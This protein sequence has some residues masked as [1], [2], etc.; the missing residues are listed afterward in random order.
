MS[1]SRRSALWL[2][3]TDVLEKVGGW[4]SSLAQWVKELLDSGTLL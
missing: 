4:M 1:T 2:I 3:G